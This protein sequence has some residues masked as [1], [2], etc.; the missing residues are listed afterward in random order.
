MLGIEDPKRIK[1]GERPCLPSRLFSCPNPQSLISP[2]CALESST[3]GGG[4]RRTSQK[5]HVCI[6]GLTKHDK[7]TDAMELVKMFPLSY[8][9]ILSGYL[10][11]V[12]A[13]DTSNS[14]FA[15]VTR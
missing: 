3:G 10:M 7:K 1:L 11:I 5:K 9:Q 8:R 12:D 6:Y 15:Y 2:K 4:P 14:V 13:P